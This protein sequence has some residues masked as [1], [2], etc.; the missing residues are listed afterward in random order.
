MMFYSQFILDKKGPLRTIWIAAHL[1]RRLRKNQVTGT[2][3][4]EAV[5]TILFAE[6]PIAL[7]LSGHLLLGV[8]KIFSKKVNYLYHDCSEALVRIKQALNSV[9][10]DLP[11]GG[12]MAPFLAITLPETCEFE[13]M[14]LDD[15]K[16]QCTGNSDHHVTTRDQI[17]LH[18]WSRD[19][20]TRVQ[21]RCHERSPCAGGPYT[22]FY[23]DE[24]S[25]RQRPS[26]HLEARNPYIA[27]L[28][29]ELMG[30]S[31]ASVLPPLPLDGPL[32]FDEMD[33][34]D[35]TSSFLS[36]EH[37]S[38]SSLSITTAS[39][40]LGDHRVE[41]ETQMCMEEPI[42]PADI[43]DCETLRS[44]EQAPL[45]EP[46]L[47]EFVKLETGKETT[48]SGGEDEGQRVEETKEPILKESPV[49]EKRIQ[50]FQR[51]PTPPTTPSSI[52]GDD[53]RLASMLD[54]TY[55]G[56][57]SPALNVMQ[58][59][60]TPAPE[61]R[62]PRSRKRK[63]IFDE[64]IILDNW[65]MRQQLTN[66]EDIRQIR[67]KV[68]CTVSEV[69]KASRFSRIQQLF[70]EP[71]IPDCSFSI[72]R[73][74]KK[75][76]VADLIFNEVPG[77]S[78]ELLGLHKRG[79]TAE[80][81]K[82]SPKEAPPKD[83]SKEMQR[84][85]LSS[86]ASEIE[87]ATYVPEATVDTH[88][89]KSN[90]L[91]LTGTEE[92]RL[93]MQVPEMSA[94]EAITE[95]STD[96]LMKVEIPSLGCAARPVNTAQAEPAGETHS[97]GFS[98]SEKEGDQGLSFLEEDSRCNAFVAECGGLSVKERDV[99]SFGNISID[100]D[101]NGLP[102]RTRAVVQYLQTAFQKSG[103]VSKINLDKV[104]SRRTRKEAA[105]MFFETLAL[106]S[107]DYI[108]VQQEEAYTGILLSAKP[109]L[110]TAKF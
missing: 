110:C 32:G 73:M 49:L 107:K 88:I 64:S 104:L 106:K 17:T 5:D 45:Q 85:C 81:A 37:T 82:V 29:E 97:M 75:D 103:T 66:T 23:L 76:R 94:T 87:K 105:R 108:E 96:E 92:L 18:D 69:F 9:H 100:D 30:V 71:S 51:G 15:V 56:G 36:I 101:S 102:T 89:E 20:P 16:F 79:F 58:T 27:S 109:K 14:E 83:P 28:E 8:V 65:L 55:A 63:Q 62:R 42:P 78:T 59:P 22:M 84:D 6:V 40:P 93:G 77:M 26:L 2:N 12:T 33:V 25:Q 48:D 61:E 41:A 60:K 80:V 70:S 68:P 38:P 54:L 90:A 21:F 35:T 95:L 31:P 44:A 57:I 13:Y 39:V 98:M 52:S 86:Q 19:F 99:G 4:S 11:S 3:I 7:R 50:G 46:H 67:R 10:I 1:E 53:A 91:D 43:P 34:D 24:E 74:D 72:S 47:V